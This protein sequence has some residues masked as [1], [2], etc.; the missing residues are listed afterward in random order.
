MTAARAG[1]RA[2]GPE[3]RSGATGSDWPEAVLHSCETE[4]FPDV[5]WQ[6]VEAEHHPALVMF[7]NVAMRHPTAWVGHVEEDVHRLACS[8][9]HRVL[10]DEVRLLDAVSCKDE[11]APSAVDVEGVRHRMIR[12]HLVDQADLDLVSNA[13]LPVD[14]GVR[15]ARIAVDELPTHGTHRYE[16]EDGT[17]VHGDASGEWTLN[18]NGG[19]WTTSCSSPRRAGCDVTR[20]A[21]RTGSSSHTADRD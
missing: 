2:T 6:D 4:T 16:L 17:I 12:V 14:G 20:D 5:P 10:P 8:D 21:Q 11:E 19:R 7:G 9:E 3:A 1:L 18:E 13:E 15:C